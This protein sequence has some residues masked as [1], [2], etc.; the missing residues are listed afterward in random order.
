MKL[1]YQLL[2]ASEQDLEMIKEAE[3]EILELENRQVAG[4]TETAKIFR[5]IEEKQIKVVANK[6]EKIGLFWAQPNCSIPYFDNVFFVKLTFVKKTYRKF[7]YPFILQAIKDYAKEC[8]YSEIFGDVFHS[9]ADSL[10]VH[11]K[12][13]EPIFTVFRAKL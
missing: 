8:G 5:A 12:L 3:K 7:F 6:D 2:D 9:N 4:E 10:K 13:A 1:H 11:S